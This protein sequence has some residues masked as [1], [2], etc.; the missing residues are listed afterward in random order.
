LI[1]EPLVRAGRMRFHDAAVCALRGADPALL[2]FDEIFTALAVPARCS[3][4]DRPASPDI[5]TRQGI[6]RR[7]CRLRR[8]WRKRV[9]EAFWS[10][11]PKRR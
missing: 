1:V 6:D 8:R 2:I 10:D 9:F 7:H 3:P 4:A 11:D 5:V